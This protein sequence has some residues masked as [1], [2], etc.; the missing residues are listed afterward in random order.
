MNYM[1]LQARKLYSRGKVVVFC[2]VIIMSVD[3]ICTTYSTALWEKV[4]GT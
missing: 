3:D 2:V 1:A 4:L